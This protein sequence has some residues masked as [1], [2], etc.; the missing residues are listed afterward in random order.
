MRS[1]FV[2][3]AFWC[4]IVLLVTVSCAFGLMIV[5]DG[6]HWPQNWPQQLEPLRSSATT[7]DFSAGA[8]ATIYTIEFC[9]RAQFERVWPSLLQL[10]SKGTPLALRT[11]D[12]PKTDSN[13]RRVLQ[14]RP[15]AV[16]S[17]PT[18]GSYL[19]M[20]DGSY[21]HRGE[22]TE[23]ITSQLDDGVL[24]RFVG[25]DPLGKW[26]IISRPNDPNF[27]EFYGIYEQARVEMTLFV[28]GEI[29]DMNRIRLPKD[30]PILD[31]RRFDESIDK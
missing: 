19:K 3:R 11:V 13:D 20:P 10:K 1:F 31:E 27:I 2:S 21:S 5:T 23:D 24:P 26:G 14:S 30:T 29:I 17:C 15:A 22:W 18:Q 6:G 8:Q 12:P 9:S 25:K 4:F 28:D 16:L 7:G